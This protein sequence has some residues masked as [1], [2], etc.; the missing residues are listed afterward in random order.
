VDCPECR[1]ALGAVLARSIVLPLAPV[2]ERVAER[3]RR[4]IAGSKM[5]SQRGPWTLRLTRRSGICERAGARN[6]EA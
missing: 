2:A 6:G 4:G 1:A 5:T 3:V